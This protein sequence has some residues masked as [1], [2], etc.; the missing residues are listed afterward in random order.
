VPPSRPRASH[1]R[2]LKVYRLRHGRKPFAHRVDT[3]APSMVAALAV[4]RDTRD[5]HIDQPMAQQTCD[6]LYLSSRALRPGESLYDGACLMRAIKICGQPAL[7]PLSSMACP[8][9]ASVA[10]SGSPLG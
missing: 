8:D 4:C 2:R 9:E 3:R 5:A 7:I 10:R 1:S 6:I